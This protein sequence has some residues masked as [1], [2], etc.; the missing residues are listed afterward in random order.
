M[1]DDW[2]IH[3]L[4][5]RAATRFYDVERDIAATQDFLGHASPATTRAY[6]AVPTDRIRATVKA[7]AA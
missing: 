2:T 5:H 4:R 1:M 3:K 7:A 6:V